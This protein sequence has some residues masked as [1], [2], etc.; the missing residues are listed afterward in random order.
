MIFKNIL[1]NPSFILYFAGTIAILSKIIIQKI[2]IR[3]I[4]VATIILCLGLGYVTYYTN[5][6][7][8]IEDNFLSS[9]QN[10]E[11]YKCG[12]SSTY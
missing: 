10:F 2:N 8:N 5:I 1:I 12:E 3:L 9:K 11:L 4:P 6:T 7:L